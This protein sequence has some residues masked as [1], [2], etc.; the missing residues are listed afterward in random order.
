MPSSDTLPITSMLK[1]QKPVRREI[2]VSQSPRNA[3]RDGLI[4][5]A[6]M[7]DD[8]IA[9]SVPVPINNKGGQCWI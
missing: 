4:H 9:V 8:R 7:A 3:S 5:F 2:T 1:T 6:M